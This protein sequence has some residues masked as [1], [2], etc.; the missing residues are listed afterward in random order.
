MCVAELLTAT[1]ERLPIRVI[2]FDD[3]ALSLIEI[4][5]RQ[6]GYETRGVAMGRIDWDAVGRGFGVTVRQAADEA[7]LARALEETRGD[8][9]PVLIAA[10]IAADTYGATM[11]A[12]RG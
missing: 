1:R 12:L 7:A 10:R 5:Q 8:S 11:Q 6:R 4:K 9:G 2:V 3:A